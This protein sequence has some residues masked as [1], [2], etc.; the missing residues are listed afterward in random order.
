MRI[1]PIT[2]ALAVFLPLLA[3]E[4]SRESFAV[5][6]QIAAANSEE[7]AWSP[8]GRRIAFDS[9]RD[10]KFLNIYLLELNTGKVIR[11]TDTKAN[12]ITP[13]WSPDGRRLAFTSD[14]TGHNEIY[15]V[16]ADGS[17]VRRVTHDESDSIHAFWSPDGK[18]LIYC[19]ARDN[20]DKGRAPEGEV[21][22]I[23]TIR[24]DGSNQRR[25]TRLGGINTYGSYSPNGKWIIFRKVL[26]ERNSEI[27]VMRADG[28]DP[29]NLTNHPAF[30][31][32]PQWSPD[33]RRIAFTSNRR[34]RGED[35]DLYLMNSDGSGLR[36]LTDVAGRNTSPKW[37]PDGS[38]ITFDQSASGRV[39]IVMIP[40]R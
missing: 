28:R 38:R 27:W 29:K 17:G 15:V 16:N 2:L 1:E 21:Y 5:P 39:R 37:S 36:R 19:S 40:V 25:L 26:G 12:D 14:R 8:D 9:N 11:L 7:S 6:E 34:G 31:A 33:G 3:P 22:E 10:G 13:A 18:T 32:W 24:P 4:P 20:P 35:Y 30:D 23:Y